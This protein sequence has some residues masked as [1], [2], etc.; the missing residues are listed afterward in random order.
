MKVISIDLE[1]FEDKKAIHEFLKKE[2]NFPEYYGCNL[3]ALY[4]CLSDN[5][6]FAFEIIHSIKF[7]KYEEALCETI[8]DAGCEVALIIK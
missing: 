1:K 2:C 6:N 5:P 4:D 8:E 7:L 3:D